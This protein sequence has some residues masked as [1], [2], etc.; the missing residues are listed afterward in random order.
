MRPAAKSCMKTLAVYWAWHKGKQRS[1]PQLRKRTERLTSPESA[2]Q[3]RGLPT[4]ALK[5]QAA[6]SADA[7]IP[8]VKAPFALPLPQ[9]K[10][11]RAFDAAR[12]IANI[13]S[14]NS[15]TP[16]AD[17][18]SA[19]GEQVE[20]ACGVRSLKNFPIWRPSRP[21]CLPVRGYPS[22][23]RYARRIRPHHQEAH[24]TAP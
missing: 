1:C 19:A 11:G 2:L 15:E 13:S 14:P 16:A 10:G 4:P 6:P 8:P 18:R 23:P 12:R 3:G 24:R 9:G 22:R 20:T 5:D 7:D 17:A 21:A